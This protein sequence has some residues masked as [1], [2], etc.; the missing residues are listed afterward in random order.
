MIS[1][2]KT[3]AA[4]RGMLQKALAI[5]AVLAVLCTITVF[6]AENASYDVELDDGTTKTTINTSSATPEEIFKEAGWDVSPLD[7]LDLS[8]FVPGKDSVI[9]IEKTTLVGVNDEKGTVYFTFDGTVAQAIDVARVEIGDNDIINYSKDQKVTDGMIISVAYA[10]PVAVSYHGEH[11]N[12][13]MAVGTVEDALEL[14]G[15]T[16]AQN[17]VV[18]HD[19][20]EVV[21][22]GMVIFVD[23]V[24]YKETTETEIIPFDTTTKKSSSYT[25][26]TSNITTKGVNGEKQVTY[27]EK[28]VNGVLIDR[29]VESETVT[30]QPVTQV[31]SIGT[32]QKTYSVKANGKPISTM[33]TVELDSNGVPKN[34]T[35]IISGS[36]TAYYGGGTTASGRP[37]MVGHV[38]VN[39]K[40]IPYG[41]RLYIVATDGTVYGY[42]IAADT[43]GFVNNTSVV[44]DVYLDTYDDCVQ[45]GRKNVNIYVLD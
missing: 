39:P 3:L 45:W 40:V 42:A 2:L 31:T 14:A 18:S 37:A 10:F 5:A 27:K 15:V 28:Y 26:G 16:L 35:R 36:S 34:Y 11:I 21:S 12:L 43:G 7:K 20:T 29:I 30:K 41:T 22:S 13:E 25:A 38:A 9:K 32:K 23:E 1:K 24:T 19:L 6:A 8:K 33:G 17:D 4:T 44:V